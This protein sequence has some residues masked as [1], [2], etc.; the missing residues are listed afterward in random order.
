MAR[1]RTELQTKLEE[2]L[3]S[4]NVYFQPPENFRMQY[5]AIV[6]SRD[7]SWDIWGD[8][9]KYLLYRGYQIALIGLDP[10]SPI[11]DRLEFLPMCSY[12]RHFNADGLN[13][14]I[15]VIYH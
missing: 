12:S 14:D 11:L 10:D 4:S 13:H 9:G 7:S 2:L 3:G 15:F 1:P 6:Y 8:N 5:P